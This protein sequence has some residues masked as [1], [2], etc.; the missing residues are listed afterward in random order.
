MGSLRA[1]PGRTEL[2]LRLRRAV[3]WMNRP[4]R[5]NSLDPAAST[6]GVRARLSEGEW[7]RLH[8]EVARAPLRLDGTADLVA[9]EFEG[10]VLRASSTHK[11]TKV[12]W[13]FL[14]GTLARGE[15]RLCSA[16]P[17]GQK[18]LANERRRAKDGT[19]E[20]LSLASLCV[21]H[22]RDLTRDLKDSRSIGRFALTKRSP[23]S[24][25]VLAE[26]QDS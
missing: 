25:E 23:T 9:R 24:F 12:R 19:E 10:G 14:W 11:G 4:R 8:A 18:Q 7:R 13:T 20:T 26:S 1:W 15:L 21:R 22:G 16:L 5:E 3:A 6:W 17:D 2:L